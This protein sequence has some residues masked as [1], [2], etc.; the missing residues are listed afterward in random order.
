[1]IGESVND[2]TIDFSGDGFAEAATATGLP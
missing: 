2:R 1:M